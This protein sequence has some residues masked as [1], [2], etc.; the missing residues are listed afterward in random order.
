MVSPPPAVCSAASPQLRG[1][2]LYG[3]QQEI[4]YVRN[5]TD[6]VRVAGTS[7]SP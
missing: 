6:A 7:F 2:A 1:I 4:H 5:A 3:L